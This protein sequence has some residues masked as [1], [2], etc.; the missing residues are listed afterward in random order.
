VIKAMGMAWYHESDYVRLREK[1]FVDGAKLHPT[2][3]QWLQAATLGFERFKSEGNIVEKIFIIPD[4]FSAWCAA[5]G[6]QLNAEARMRFVNEA[7]AK[8][9]VKA[10]V[11]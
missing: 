5:N 2:Y 1:L 8:K 3:S 4:E 7:V 11:N 10:A 9:Y 6:R